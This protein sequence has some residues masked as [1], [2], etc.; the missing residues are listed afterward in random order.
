MVLATAY[1]SY[2]E[3]SALDV[4][5]GSQGNRNSTPIYRQAAQY[6]E[7]AGFIQKAAESW[8]SAGDYTKAAELLQAHGGYGKAATWYEKAG[9]LLDAASSYR[10]AAMYDDAV[11]TYR[12]GEHFAELVSFMKTFGI[13]R[14]VCSRVVTTNFHANFRAP[15]KNTDIRTSLVKMY[16]CD[17]RPLSISFYSAVIFNFQKHLCL[18]S[19]AYWA[20]VPQE[21]SSILNMKKPRT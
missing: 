6:F 12:K 20:E 2:E 7:G 4:E 10:Q 13:P 21:K 14:P 8:G 16:E 19:L 15:S 18:R 3:A 5:A 17:I 1:L 11:R 9:E